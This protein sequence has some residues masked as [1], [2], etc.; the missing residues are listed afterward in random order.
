MSVATDGIHCLCPSKLPLGIGADGRPL[1]KLFAE[2]R[3]EVFEEVSRRLPFAHWQTS[4][5]DDIGM[6]VLE[7][8]ATV[9][10]NLSFYNDLWTREQHLATAVQDASLRQLAALTGYQPRPNLAAM[11]RIA[12]ISDAR[13]PLILPPGKA[14]IS[15]GTESH[16]ALTFETSEA[17]EIDPGLSA[18]N[19]IPRRETTFD[20][21]FVAIDAGQRN[22]RLDEPVLFR[23]GTTTRARMLTDI[24]QDKFPTG[25]SFAELT[26]D[27]SLSVF[28]GAPLSEIEVMSFSGQLE[29]DGLANHRIR[30]TAIQPAL[31]EGMIVAALDGVTGALTHGAIQ[32]VVYDTRTLVDDADLP[33]QTPV[34]RIRLASGI[35]SGNPVTLFFGLRRGGRLIG[36]PMTRMTLNDFADRI[37]LEERYIGPTPDHQGDFVVVDAERRAVAVTARLDVHS[38]TKR[39]ALDLTSIADPGLLLKAPL[40]IHGNFAYAD[41]GKSIAETL[42]SATG[43]RYQTFRLS[44]KPLTFLRRDDADPAPAL[45][46]YVDSIPWTYVPHLYGVEPDDR[47]FTLR[48]EAD[49]QA[50]VILGGIANAGDK[51]VAARYRYGTTGDNPGAFTIVMPAG[52]MEGVREVFN[53]FSALGGLKGDSADDLRFVLP[54]RTSANDRAVSAEDYVVLS[55]SFGALAAG[56]ATAWNATRKTTSVAVVAAFD[57]GHDPAL[58]ARLRDY[59]VGHAPDGSLVDVTSATPRPGTVALTVRADR[60]ARIEDVEAR[61]TDL[62]LHTFTG[63]L[64]P[65]RARIGRGWSRT[66]VLAPLDGLPGLARVERLALDGSETATSLPLASDEYLDAALDLEVLR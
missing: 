55:R 8:L 47:V 56:V 45:E 12:L 64:S 31:R 43:R 20:P 60:D 34:T 65:R 9:L 35:T 24:A 19:A 41:Q 6:M 38:R 29:G 23:R 1:P 53:P 2:H 52:R 16:P 11:A 18:L 22:L 10:D 3:I 5:P 21:D 25:E 32:N 57:G 46:V 39:A 42:G 13:A 66:E 61:L 28:D 51:N 58:A 4:R 40:E 63:L 14:I 44:K 59:L 37:D 7:W 48:L 15:E 50:H 30:F 17:V 62:Y 54:A 49:G 33:V 27:G 36:A 26:V